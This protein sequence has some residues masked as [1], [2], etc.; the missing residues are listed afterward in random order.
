MHRFSCGSVSSVLSS[1]HSKLLPHELRA[2]LNNA[3]GRR[4][5]AQMRLSPAS[6]RLL[7]A[8]VLRLPVRFLSGTPKKRLED[9]KVH[10]PKIKFK[11]RKD[12]YLVYAVRIQ[13]CPRVFVGPKLGWPT[14]AQVGLR[15]TT[16]RLLLA[17][18]FPF[19]PSSSSLFALRVV[20]IGPRARRTCYYT[21]PRARIFQP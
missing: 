21:C 19:P 14:A 10:V 18:D 3:L 17:V 13:L 20:F 2:P 7:A 12:T 5:V 9:D 6:N 1:P 11:R 4:T 15:P 8:A 16:Y